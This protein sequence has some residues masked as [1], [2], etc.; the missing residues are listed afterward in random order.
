MAHLGLALRDRVERLKRRHE[1]AARVHLDLQLAARHRSDAL[2]E[3][4]RAGAEIVVATPGRLLDH[5]RFDYVDLTAVEIAA[6]N[7]PDIAAVL[8]EPILG[9]GG[10]VI[11]AADYLPRLRALCDT[12]GWLLMLDEIQTGMGRTGALFSYQ[13]N[14]ILPDVVTL[15]KGLGNG[16]PIGACL[17]RGEAARV[18]GPGTHGSTFGGNPLAAAVALEALDIIEQEKL[19][20]R[21]MELG[22]YFLGRL[23][24]ISSPL[25]KDVRGKGLLIGLEVHPECITARRVCEALMTQGILSKETHDTVI[26]FAP[27]LVVTREQLDWAAELISQVFKELE[28]V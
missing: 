4:L 13:S 23:K 19:A 24:G 2:G 28:A 10:I 14:G 18:L 6:A 1:L 17:A 3:A 27:P 21:A 20:E 16:F 8:V 5:M 15:A 26:R 7:R 12:H 25:I 11:P 22:D 9:E